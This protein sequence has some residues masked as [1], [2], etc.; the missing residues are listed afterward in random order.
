M[1]NVLII[2]DDMSVCRLLSEMVKRLDHDATFAFTLKDGLKEAI[3]K[4]FDVVFLDVMLPDGSGINIVP[5][6]RGKASSPEIISRLKNIK[7]G[8]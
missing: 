7:T 4:D 2:D 8:V 3:S 1:A 6:I 5:Q